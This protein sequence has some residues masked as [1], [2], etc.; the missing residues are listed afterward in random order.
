M[1]VFATFRSISKLR[2]QE[3]QRLPVTGGFAFSFT[4]WRRTAWRPT[5]GLSMCRL[6]LSQQTPPPPPLLLHPNH[7][8]MHGWGGGAQG[9][10]TLHCMCIFCSLH[11]SPL[12]NEHVNPFL[13][14]KNKRLF[15]SSEGFYTLEKNALIC[16]QSAMLPF[17]SGVTAL[18]I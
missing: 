8:P 7:E 9:Y 16:Y 14:I 15:I 4:V 17:Q 1:I 2:Y 6:S 5:S 10:A 3:N 13:F 18:C 12:N 11:C